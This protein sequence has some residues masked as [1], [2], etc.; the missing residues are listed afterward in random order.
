MIMRTI[1][2]AGAPATSAT[3]DAIA[4]WKLVAVSVLGAIVLA[5]TLMHAPASPIMEPDSPSY[6]AFASFRSAAYPLFLKLVGAE[7]AL[8]VQPILAALALTYLGCELLALTRSILAA[9]GTML[10][11]ALNPF[12]VVYHYKIMSESLYVSLVM[13]LLGLLM[14]LSRQPSPALAAAASLI[15][16]VMIAVRPAG[17]FL[18]PLLLLAALMLRGRAHSTLALAAAA[19]VPLLAVTAAESS[20]RSAWHHGNVVSLLNVAL[21]GKAGMIEAPPSGEQSPAVAALEQ[22]YAPIRRIVAMSPDAA[23]ERFLVVNYE[24]CIEYSCSSSLGISSA[25]DASRRAAL[26]RI[27]ANPYGFLALAWRHYTGLWT[28]NSASHPGEVDAVNAFLGANRPMPFEAEVSAFSTRV[29]PLAPALIGQPA[30]ELIGLLTAILTVAALAAVSFRHDLPSV[31]IVALL[32][33]LAV[34]GAFVLNALTG[35]GIPRYML[36]MWP[37]M[38]LMLTCSAWSLIALLQNTVRSVPQPGVNSTIATR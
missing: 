1:Q 11:I 15:A 16:G 18:L 24:T 35:V 21:Y 4:K 6:L 19:V 8:T 14:R 28:G 20:F 36:A 32:C 22:S 17:W 34:Q 38:M 29:E 23:I 7:G 9:S 37:A 33:A 31:R 10:A 27:A 5:G 3:S 12:L 26:Q 25:S 2:H 30:L 13:V